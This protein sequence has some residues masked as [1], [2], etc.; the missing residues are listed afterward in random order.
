MQH[1]PQ[2][3]PAPDD[4]LFREWQAYHRELPHLLMH[5]QVGKFALF[6][7]DDFHGV[8]A[9]REQALVAGIRLFLPQPFLVSPRIAFEAVRLQQTGSSA[10]L[11][12]QFPS[13]VQKRFARP[14]PLLLLGIGKIHYTAFTEAPPDDP[15][16]QEWR[17]YRRELPRLLKEG[18]ERRFCLFK[19]DDLLGLFDTYEEAR[20]VGMERFLLEPFLARPILEYDPVLRSDRW[21]QSCRT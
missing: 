5:G 4:P 1:A 6:S 16:F 7:G 10:G 2:P 15:L 12:F 3:E 19:G 11:H 9:T 13:Q 17:A 14:H 18:H 21:L 8:F 20:T